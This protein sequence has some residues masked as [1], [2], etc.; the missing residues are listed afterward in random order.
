MK[1]DKEQGELAYY[2]LSCSSSRGFR[3]H[4]EQCRLETWVGQ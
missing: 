1:S 2:I 3:F 4:D